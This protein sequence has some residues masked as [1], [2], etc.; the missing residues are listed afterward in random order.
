MEYLHYC[1]Y[2]VWKTPNFG[3]ILLVQ[4]PQL[5]QKLLNREKLEPEL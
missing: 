4:G 5:S 1:R 2:K 3:D